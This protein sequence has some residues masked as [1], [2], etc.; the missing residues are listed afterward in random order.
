M[1]QISLFVTGFRGKPDKVT[2][3]EKFLSEMDQVIPWSRLIEVIKPHYPE[4]GNGRPPMG[5]A[6]TTILQ[7]IIEVR[8]GVLVKGAGRPICL[9]RNLDAL[10]FA[11]KL[12][13]VC[14]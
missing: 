7:P 8:F 4:A 5:L 2:K 13:I 14:P 10:P 1:K 11:E 3:R 12:E 6:K 9:H